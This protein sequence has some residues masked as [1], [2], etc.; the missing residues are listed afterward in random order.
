ML[1]IARCQNNNYYC[2]K[3]SFLLFNPVLLFLL[4]LYCFLAQVNS[5]NQQ[6]HD[7]VHGPWYK[8]AVERRKTAEELGLYQC[9]KP[10]SKSVYRILLGVPECKSNFDC[11][12]GG[13]CIKDRAG[14]GR[15]FCSS[16]CPLSKLL[17]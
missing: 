4:H 9:F 12:V 8:R 2:K 6:K 17:P 16:S 5:G 14:K 11:V 1:R 7:V 10:K 3:I 15:C 13:V